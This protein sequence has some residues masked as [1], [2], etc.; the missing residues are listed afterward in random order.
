MHEPLAHPAPLQPAEPDTATPASAAPMMPTLT[1][2]ARRQGI[3][4]AFDRA[5]AHYDEAAHIQRGLGEQPMSCAVQLILPA[6]PG[7]I[8][9]LT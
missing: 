3:R 8:D 5:A 6:L 1:P 2:R 4:N 9:G 7:G